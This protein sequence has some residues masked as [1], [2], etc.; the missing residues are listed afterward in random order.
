MVTPIGA[1]LS[2][3]KGLKST[4]DAAVEKGL[5][6]LQ[7]FLRNPRGRGARKL[8][9]D[10]TD[11]FIR[12]IEENKIGPVV[13]HIPYICNPAA[14]KP[15]VY[16]FAQQVITEDLERCSLINADYLVL[17]PGSYTTSSPEEGIDKLG[18]LINQV[19]ENYEGRTKVLLETMAGQ[20]TEIGRNFEELKLIMDRIEQKDKVGICYDTCH[21]YAAGYDCSNETGIKDILHKMKTS[22]GLDKIYLVHAND[23]MKELGGAR[24]R[25]AHIGHGFIGIEGFRALLTDSFF[26][27]FA[28]ILET[29]SEGVDADVTVLKELRMKQ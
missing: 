3:G 11:Y 12:V 17:H 13:V 2:I 8:S 28:F 27:Q 9:A 15:D 6:A 25:H 18:G 10:E 20:G 5:E 21:T 7:I 19:L 1:H 23:S 16:E 24:D 14:A 29:P 4:A 22:F 26:S